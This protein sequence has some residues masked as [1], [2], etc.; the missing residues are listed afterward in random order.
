[1]AHGVEKGLDRFRTICFQEQFG[2]EGDGAVPTA[3]AAFDSTANIGPNVCLPA[4]VVKPDV[5]RDTVKIAANHSCSAKYLPRFRYKPAV[6]FYFPKNGFRGLIEP[7]ERKT[8]W[9]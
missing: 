7:T 6:E 8:L 2:S 3:A 1:M 5:P 9:A 4:G